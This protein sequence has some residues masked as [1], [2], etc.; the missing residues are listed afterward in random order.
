V[1]IGQPHRSS[2]RSRADKWRG[3]RNTNV[4][5]KKAI[6]RGHVFTWRSRW[7]TCVDLLQACNLD[8]ELHPCLACHEA[9]I[10]QTG[11][12]LLADRAAGCACYP[13]P[14]R[15]PRGL[16]VLGYLGR[17]R[18]DAANIQ[19]GNLKPALSLFLLDKG[20]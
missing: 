3:K 11:R 10:Q 15:W 7:P 12:W 1:A 8:A 17:A 13:R 18:T 19:I 9:E 4:K 5:E 14:D 6:A 16:Q 20:R 2:G